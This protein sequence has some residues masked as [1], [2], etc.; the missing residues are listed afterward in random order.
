MKRVV[1]VFLVALLFASIKVAY[2][3]PSAQGDVV[4]LGMTYPVQVVWNAKALVA[5]KSTAI[6]VFV[7]STFTTRVWA[8]INITYNFGT[9]W[10]LETGPYGEGVPIDPGDNTIYLPGGPALPGLPGRWD[11]LHFK[12][13]LWTRTGLDD[14]IEVVVDPLG[15]LEETDETNNR[16][17]FEV[18]VVETRL[19]K[20]LV[21]PLGSN[22]SDWSLD[23]N[24]NLNFLRDTYPVAQVSWMIGDPI[25]VPGG[26]GHPEADDLYR[27][28]VQDLSTEARILGYDRVVVVIPD[29]G[30][31]SDGFSWGGMAVGML[32][33][34][35]DRVPV[36]VSGSSLNQ[37][38]LVA[39]ELGHTYYLWHPHGIG[40]PVYEATRYWVNM[41]DYGQ[42][43]N[44]LMSY[45]SPPYWIDNGRYDSDPKTWV[46]LR[47]QYTDV[48]GTWLWNLFDQFR[49]MEIRIP[50]VVVG[51]LMFTNGTV[52]FNRNFYRLSNGVPDVSTN[53]Q[54][55]PKG[56]YSLLLLNNNR[57]TLSQIN[58]NV[59]FTFLAE[60]EGTLVKETT[61]AAPF[62]FNVPCP[63]GVNFIQI[64][65]AT[66]HTLAE[67][68]VTTN[69][70]V[71]NVK[72]PNGGESLTIG[73]NYTVTWKSYDPDEDK[74]SYIVT[75]S[76]DGGE[77][78]IPLA[79]V[80]EAYYVWN[81]SRL[82]AGDKY[83]VKV[84]ATDG[85]NTGEDCSNSTF[86][87]LD[88]TPPA[89]SDITQNPSNSVSPDQSVTVYA[90]VSD[91]NSGLKK[92]TLSYRDSINNDLK[93]SAWT[94]ITM[95]PTVLNTFNGNIPG[96][97]YGTLVQYMIFAE[98]NSNNSAT[99]DNAG[100]YYVYTVIPEFNLIVLPLFIVITF[101]AVI[102]VRKKYHKK[103]NAKGISCLEVSS[104]QNASI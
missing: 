85:V 12:E 90:N 70:P 69:P 63:D 74:L 14:E 84:I 4:N 98:D 102:G 7:Q 60:I 55:P 35:E 71:V 94:N 51:G 38:N 97:P 79:N 80:N 28:W 32:R 30:T 78:W 53:T 10:Y 59:S 49:E 100:G 6:C 54:V 36:I 33:A 99:A 88:V 65:N 50:V 91:P 64:R 42:P 62:L 5:N 26:L 45:R 29:Y 66:G 68:E 34:P 27:Q 57:Q 39:H 101:F 2:G 76:R 21:V 96:F 24:A 93:W 89:I 3:L 47:D 48:D 11:F 81:T 103:L 18:D 41:R 16:C 83:L 25:E 73:T 15:R 56:N 72:F 31:E 1:S 92:V 75:Y 86:T 13:L 44:T 67:K 19:L 22:P 104:K 82:I 8:E 9:E 37:T 17:T 87:L 95:K 58:F 77:T 40:P 46:D 61:D 20:I 23:L 43:A 52:Q